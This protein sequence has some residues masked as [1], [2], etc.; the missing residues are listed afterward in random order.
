MLRIIIFCIGLII[1]VPAWADPAADCE[2]DEDQ[3]LK[4]KGCTEIIVRG[5]KEAE[6]A[7]A[8]LNRGI[9]YQLKGENDRAIA[10]FNKA[11]ELN[12]GYSDA[13]IRRAFSYENNG[14]LDRAIAEYSKAIAVDPN[15]PGAYY[16]RG[17]DYEKKDDKDRAIADFRKAL[18]IDPSDNDT[19]EALKRLGAT[20]RTDAVAS[21]SA[22][23]AADCSQTEDHDLSIK[24]CTE[25]ISKESETKQNLA[26]AYY[27]RG[28]SYYAKVENDRAIAD[29]TMAIALDPKYALA[30]Y[31]RGNIYLHKSDYDRAIA[32]YT[33]AIEIDPKDAAFY[34]NRGNMYGDKGDNDRAIADYTKAIE[35]DPKYENTYNNRGDAYAN[36][37]D[38]DRAIADYT[39]DLEINPD[40]FPEVTYCARARAYEKKGDMQHAKADRDASNKLDEGYCK[41]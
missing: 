10:D 24:A 40:D 26:V 15:H 12:P 13:Y 11:I 37:G 3:D 6:L 30:Y 2:Q 39:K 27:N 8:Y 32:D 17:H 4:I 14:D 7:I 28:A 20:P 19:Q 9:S 23:P 16:D 22:D 33:K 21:P 36:K 31:N 41:Q 29:Y 1:A 25:I 35:I 38:Y 34:Y 5:H 18:S